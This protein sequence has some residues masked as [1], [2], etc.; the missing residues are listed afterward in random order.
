M[1]SI[2]RG[3]NIPIYT[4]LKRNNN[5]RRAFPAQIYIYIQYKELL[6][7]NNLIFPYKPCDFDIYVYVYTV[8]ISNRNFD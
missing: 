4:L 1:L 5:N 7:A 6:F 2:K 8:I 3:E